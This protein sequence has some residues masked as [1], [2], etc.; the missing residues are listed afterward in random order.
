MELWVVQEAL[1]VLLLISHGRR[2][3][4]HFAVTDHPNASW[5][6]QQIRNA[7]AYGHQPKYLIHDNGQPFK[8][9]SFQ[10]FLS[11]SNVIS[12]S[13]TPYYHVRANT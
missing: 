9:K 7:T 6:I 3:I 4:E 2:K 8:D 11:S 12:K 1:Y 10:E 5:L 13:I